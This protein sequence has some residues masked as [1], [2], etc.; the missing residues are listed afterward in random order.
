MALKDSHP[1]VGDTT[2]VLD[3][4]AANDLSSDLGDEPGR[5]S[6]RE[7]SPEVITPSGTKRELRADPFALCGN[8]DPHRLDGGCI[9]GNCISHRGHH[10]SLVGG[11]SKPYVD[12]HRR[13]RVA[14]PAPGRFHPAS[15][16]P[17]PSRNPPTRLSPNAGLQSRAGSLDDVQVE[18]LVGEV[19]RLRPWEVAEAEWYVEARDDVVYQF[20]TEDPELTVREVQEA[21]R[22]ARED[23]ELAAFAITDELGELVGNLALRFIADAAEISYFL[24]PA[25]R[26]R[27]LATDAVRVAA[28]WAIE[29]GAHRVVAQ[30][31]TGNTASEAVLQRNG[32]ERT[33]VGDHPTL[34]VVTTWT[35]RPSTKSPS[36]TPV[37]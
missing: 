22:Q 27:G 11:P 25:G 13:R 36:D 8:G 12:S 5:F 15:A 10:E 4:D 14:S 1:K 26:G 31:A 9:G 37:G 3:E 35:L 21:I 28:S 34:G 2:S 33:G 32:F 29:R 18:V 17:P 7:Y 24:T 6:G 23:T 19:A 20:T 16:H 30:V